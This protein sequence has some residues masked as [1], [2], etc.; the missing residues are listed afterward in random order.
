MSRDSVAVEAFI[1]ASVEVV[2]RYLT[3]ARDTW[4]PEMQFDA[5]VGSPLVE[6]WIEDGRPATATGLVTASVEPRLLGFHWIEPRW[7]HP[8]D[9]MIRLAPS[10]SATSVALTESG[11]L[12]AQSPPSLP[13]EHEAGWTYHLAR[14]KRVS[15][16]EAA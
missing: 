2:W 6:T 10:G 16:G 11:F 15:E 5:V 1:D 4:W 9:V 13:A 7:A 8:L 3:A 12:R 14:L